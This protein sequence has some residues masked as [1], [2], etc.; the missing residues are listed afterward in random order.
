MNKELK[1][2]IEAIKNCKVT[3]TYKMAWLR[4]ITEYLILNP[5]Q[6]TINLESLSELIFKYYWNQTIFFQLKQSN[7]PNAEPELL[8][9]V[10]KEI[11]RF[12]TIT[13]NFKPSKYLR[14]QDQLQVNKSEIIKVLKKDVI[15]RFNNDINLYEFDYSNNTISIHN[16][17]LLITNA[18]IIF[19]LV[20][21]RWTS[22]LEDFNF[23]P[24]IAHKVQGAETE[25]IRRG[26]LKKFHR[27]IEIEN[28]N[29]LCFI[30][31]TPINSNNLSVHHVIPWSYM[32]SD[33]LWNLVY[34]DKNENSRISNSIPDQNIIN[35]LKE[36]NNNLKSNMEDLN[37]KNK[38]FN[39]LK[40]AIDR[41]LVT[42]YWINCRG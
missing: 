11:N 5:N 33:D 8:Q 23:A 22:I 2:L 16:P 4:S 26:N 31:N 35:K 1:K 39:E 41:D 12:Q 27:Y 17:N 40:Y 20:N 10:R 9:I 34:V 7:D 6:R 36:R 29:K 32:Y 37:I 30:T 25:N 18:D 24:R 21:Y 15:K 19:E 13:Q 42:S 28:P 14:V 38:V 3:S